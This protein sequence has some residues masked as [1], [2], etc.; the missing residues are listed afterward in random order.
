M[1]YSKFFER[2]ISEGN[3]SLLSPY[4]MKRVMKIISIEGS[5]A[6]LKIEK[7]KIE[8]SRNP[9]YFNMTI[10]NYEMELTKLSRNLTPDD[11]LKEM[12]RL[13]D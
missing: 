6:S 4:E 5:I 13:S 7:D 2:E 8:N 1:K 9:T 3:L 10:F 11:L 12:V